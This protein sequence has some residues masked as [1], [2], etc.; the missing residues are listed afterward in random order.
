MFLWLKLRV[1]V[2]HVFSNA[3]YLVELLLYGCEF[4]HQVVCLVSAILFLQLEHESRAVCDL[5]LFHPTISLPDPLR[6]VVIAHLRG[7]PE[8]EILQ[9]L[10]LQSSRRNP[11]NSFELVDE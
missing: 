1:C 9:C 5:V 4:N 2:P 8:I 6:L 11:E 3:D 7:E 10:Q